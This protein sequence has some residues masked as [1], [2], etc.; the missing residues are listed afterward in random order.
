[1]IRVI[2]SMR[3]ILVH[4]GKYRKYI[5][6]GYLVAI[7]ESN[8]AFVPYMLLFYL[9][10]VG[11][12]RSFERKDFYTV[13]LGMVVSVALRAVFK[14][15]HDILQQDKG[16][17]AFA[18]NRLK[19]TEHLA[20]LNMGYYTDGNIGNITSVI[21]TDI[22]FIEEYAMMQMGILISGMAS[23]V[24]ST[25]FLFLFDFRL[26]ALY[27]GL[28]LIGTLCLGCFLRAMNRNARTRQDNLSRLSH[29]VLNFMR[30][31]QT[32]KAFN[33]QRE[34]ST[35]MNTEIERT[36]KGSLHFVT[37]VA[38]AQLLF[39]LGSSLPTAAMI[40]YISH[41]ILAR[42]FDL[43]Y[44]LGF[45]VFS[46]V[47]FL[48]LT[49]FGNA[50]EILEIAEAS[51]ERYNV[52]MQEKEMEDRKDASI[53]I[54]KM[55]IQFRDVSFAYEEKQVLKEINL[56][57][58]DRSFTALVGRSGS[59][60]TTIAN[61]IA[62]FWDVEEGEIRIDGKNIKEIPTQTLLSNIS[63]VFQRV[64]LFND[65]IYNNIAFGNPKATREEVIEAAKKARCHD[66]ILKLE[67][68]YDTMVGEGGS[69]LSGGEKQRISIARAILKDAP[70]IL[71]DESTAGI[72]PENER[73]IQEA[74]EELVRDKTLIVIAHRLSTI[75]HADRIV[76]MEDGRILESGTH[77]ELLARKGEYKKQ[78]DFYSRKQV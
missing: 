13:F 16:Y 61:L 30:G 63:M 58:K 4:L 9:I 55:D 68:G 75:R 12:E 22:S 44:G 20:K 28:I 15:L 32:I 69:T 24:P 59:G 39:L 10:K 1:M 27:L 60:K 31:M 54:E 5:R 37:D 57:I 76:Y 52:I 36:Q 50:A 67:Q 42:G 71:L 14:R 17:Y 65:T 21:T 2:K 45:I 19:L 11:I 48:P 72:D 29:A 23:L 26:G 66:F 78:Y 8:M 73:F 74:I 6:L 64:Y 62:R 51:I 7:L 46:F 18:E 47:I 34:K 40:I 49:L 3:H 70:L 43:A 41:L 33:M 77:E 35:E 25:I 38:G 53:P 56:E